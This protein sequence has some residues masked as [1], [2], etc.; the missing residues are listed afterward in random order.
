MRGDTLQQAFDRARR[1]VGVPFLRFHDLRHTGQTLAAEAGASLADLMRRAGHS[2]TVAAKR[3]LHATDA[4]D[5]H[6]ASALSQLAE[7]SVAR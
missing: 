3:Y 4:R 5:R 1:K 2:S 7:Q 6:L